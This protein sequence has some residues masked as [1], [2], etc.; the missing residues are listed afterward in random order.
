MATKQYGTAQRIT[1]GN[2]SPFG[3]LAVGDKHDTHNGALIEQLS[4]TVFD[5]TITFYVADTNDVH[6]VYTYRGNFTVKWL[7]MKIEQK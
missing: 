1:F 4:V 6:T 2:A 3:Q 5:D 7:E